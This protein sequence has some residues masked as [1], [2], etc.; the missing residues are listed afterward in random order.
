MLGDKLEE[1]GLTTDDI[2]FLRRLFEREYRGL[3]QYAKY[4][5]K[6]ESNSEDLV[7]DAFLIALLKIDDVRK[8]QNQVLWLYK[9]MKNLMNNRRRETARLKQAI[10][11][12]GNALSL[13]QEGEGF[14]S[15]MLFLD[16]CQRYIKRS[17][18]LLICDYYL[19][20]Y[21]CS[22]LSVRMGISESACRMRVL[23]AKR[24]L[25]E[26]LEESY[27]ISPKGPAPKAHV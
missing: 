18:W 4:A 9:T 21:T 24:I 8:S 15:E 26:K 22:E 25:A 2:E 7:Q 16:N 11:K 3:L 20:G 23:R 14:D 10:E 27:S 19:S 5:L 1:R 6:G 12:C 13:Q 17:D